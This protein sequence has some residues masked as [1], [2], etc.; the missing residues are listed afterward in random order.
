ML[1]Q[2]ILMNAKTDTGAGTTYM[3][4]FAGTS[5]IQAWITGPGTATV[6]I[7]VSNNNSNWLTLAT[8]SLDSGG[9][10]SDGFVMEAPWMYVRGNVS[11]ITGGSITIKGVAK[12]HFTAV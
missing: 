10:T 8:M 5:T 2:A 11:A 4:D 6:L 12:G 7:Q 9:T 3:A 1:G